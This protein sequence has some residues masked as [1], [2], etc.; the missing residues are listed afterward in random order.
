[1]LDFTNKKILAPMVRVGTLPMRLLALE[2][3]AD[4]VYTEEIIDYRLLKCKRVEN[5]LLN[6]VDFIDED[7]N[8]V[9]RTCEK[10]KKSLVLQLG[11]ASPE[12]ALKA[13]KM[14]E[15]EVSAIDV[16]MGCPKE[17]SIK[18][19]MGAALLT[20][21]DKV[22]AILSTLTEGLSCPVTCKIRILPELDKT[23]DLVKLIE[24]TGVS[25]IAVHGR[26]MGERPQ[27]KNRN[28]VIKAI[29]ETISIP[30]IAN[31]LWNLSDALNQ[32]RAEMKS[33]A[34]TLKRFPDQDIE[35]QIALKRRRVNDGDINEMD[36]KFLRTNFDMDDLPKT[37]LWNWAK[38]QNIDQPKYQ[39][40][41]YEK[42]FQSVVHINGKKY[43]N[44]CLE[45]NKKNAEQAAALVAV[46]SLGLGKKDVNL[47]TCGLESTKDF[48]NKTTPP[49]ALCNTEN[50]NTLTIR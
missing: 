15:K 3:G 24:Q 42:S 20:K 12:R 47:E 19:G 32:K 30:V 8:V 21:P 46:I 48:S 33:K 29:A 50:N 9:F 43:T 26:I 1:M 14:V 41:Q 27:H 4:I 17:F 36:I 44:L 28:Y 18:G 31:G 35:L 5:K 10:E 16:N 13:A 11:T 23:L 39:T 49:D 2:C 22:K 25:A 34:E 6:T 37:V 38:G 40:D 45:K 7:Q